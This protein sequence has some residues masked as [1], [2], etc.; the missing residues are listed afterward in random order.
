[1]NALV[2]GGANGIGAATAL[3]LAQNGIET[4]H[5]VDIDELGLAVSAGHARAA[6]AV[7]VEH[8]FSVADNAAWV[9]L[10]GSA[11]FVADPLNILVNNAYTATVAVIAEQTATDWRHQIDVNLV[12]QFLA[13]QAFQSQLAATRGAIVNVSSVHAFAGIAGYSAYAASKGGILAL[14]RQLAVELGPH[15]RV[16]AVV[17]GPILTAAWDNADQEER[18]RSAAAT[19]LGRLGA[20]SEVAAA[21]AFLTSADASF[22]TGATLAVDGGWLVS[23][24]SV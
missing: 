13:A 3:R 10:A 16:N 23:K 24:D 7:V 2:T 8:V 1:M 4:I 11:Q 20:A 19:A 21:I 9:D 15:I 12:G 5:L 22:I 14:T 6:G 17:P 18:D